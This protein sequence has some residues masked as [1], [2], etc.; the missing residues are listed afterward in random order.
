M[1]RIY[2]EKY[3]QLGA[4]IET[5]QNLFNQFGIAV[6]G[7]YILGMSPEDNKAER[8][9]ALRDVLS[10][11]TEI[12][13]SLNL[14]VSAAL[15]DGR[16]DLLPQ[17]PAELDILMH[18]VITELKSK[19][20]LFVPSESAKYY[21]ID[22]IVSELTKDRFPGASAEIR[23]AATCFALD[24]YTAAVFHAMRAAEIGIRALAEDAKVTLKHH[25]ELADWQDI[26]RG[27]H[28]K[29]TEIGRMPRSIKRD[30]DLEFYS[31]SA[32]QLQ[33]F[34]DGWRVRVMHARSVYSQS[35]AQEALEHVRSFFDALSIRLA[36]PL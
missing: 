23:A 18:A 33:F 7:E 15:I 31:Q 24:Q 5:A 9:K 35:Q 12:C 29:I 20:F 8:E 6:E 17:T 26:Q 25:I 36:E 22:G 32:A 3:I 11:L 10:D 19:L 14:S 1:L 34:K 27:L 16:I 2:A 28:E 21:E 13:I 30:E 4:K